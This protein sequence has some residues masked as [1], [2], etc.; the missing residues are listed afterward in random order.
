MQ[1]HIGIFDAFLFPPMT[2]HMIPFHLYGVYHIAALAFCAV[3]MYGL[4]YWMR[5]IET[6]TDVARIEKVF[7][8]ALILLNVETTIAEVWNGIWSLAEGLPFHLCDISAWTL[9][10]A[11]FSRNERAFQAG[12]FWGMAGGLAG[13]ALPEVYYIDV[14]YAPFF[15]WHF[16][17]VA[18]P[19]YLVRIVGFRPTHR[20]LWETLGITAVISAPIGLAVWLIPN[21]NYMFLKRPPQAFAG[22][23]FMVWPWYLL[24]LFGLGAVIFYL[25]WLPFAPQ[26]KRIWEAN[27]VRIRLRNR[28]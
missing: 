14:Y 9:I 19:L 12:Y 2:A 22:L 11:M 1:W 7:L 18:M 24:F 8:W 17:L 3:L 13:L 28:I 25:L 6:P 20:G 26:T 4:F 23:A 21:A 10:Y 5:R 27:P 15:F 16:L